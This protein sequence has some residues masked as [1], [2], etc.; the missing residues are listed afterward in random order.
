[1]SGFLNSLRQLTKYPSAVVGLI[2]ILALLAISVYTV[3]AIPYSEAI[4]LW[5]GGEDVWYNYPKTAG[6]AWTNIFRSQD[7][8]ETISVSSTDE[9]VAKTREAESEEMTDVTF[10]LTFDYPYTT[11]PEELTVFYTAQ[12]D[13]KAPHISMTWL[14]PDGREIRIGS[15]SM[16]GSSMSFRV[17]QESTLKRRLGGALPE[18]GLFADPNSDPENPVALPGT[19][20]MEVSSIVFEEGSDLDGELV[21]YGKVHGLAGTDNRRRDLMV[22]L[23]WGTPIAL[24]FGLLAAVG[25]SVTTMA[26]AGI[27][28]WFG[29]WVD[30]LIQRV[31]E[32]NMVLPFLPIL[33][34]VGTFYSKSLWLMLGVII[35]LN[36]FGGS[37]KTYRA[38][39]MQVRQ[40]AYIEAAQAYGAT[41]SRLIFSYLIPRI[42]P[43]LIPGLVVLIPSFV[44][45]EAALAVLGLGDPILPTWG[46]VI[47]DAQSTGA[48]HQAL[49]YWVL[50]PSVLLMVTG[51]AFSLLGF[52][53]DRIFN[54]RLRGL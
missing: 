46:K 5:R 50:E 1:M 16:E 30:G 9:D 13:A 34:M 22:A 27:G 51:L 52:S 3:I 15:V 29:G 4:R 28:T 49:Y 35:L 37:I 20:T 25:T 11:F 26:I 12:Y 40:S 33:I 32:V 6:P 41:N 42:I 47:N 45:I 53:L 54:P 24:A 36:I 48:L 10:F 2:I 19:Y 21:V 17:S 38:M 7:L 31:T 14:T 8:P 39:F 18:I 43:M 23:L 44:F